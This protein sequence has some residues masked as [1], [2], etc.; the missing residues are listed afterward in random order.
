MECRYEVTV[1]RIGYD[2]E[3]MGYDHI[4]WADDRETANEI[5]RERAKRIMVD[6][7]TWWAMYRKDDNGEPK[8]K[9]LYWG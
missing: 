8:M 1:E 7:L 2:G 4:A 9:I 6:G 5:A 3:F